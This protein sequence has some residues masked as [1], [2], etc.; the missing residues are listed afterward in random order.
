VI[1]YEAPQGRRVN[2]IGAYFTH[3][4]AV[5]TLCWASYASLPKSRAKTQQRSVAEQAVRHGLLPEEVGVLDSERFLAFLW[6]VAGRPFI[7]PAG[8][9]RER[10]LV[11]VLDNYSVHKSERVE[12]ALPELTAADIHLFYLPAYTPELSQMEPVWHAVKHHELT[13]R[14]F[15]IL[16]QLK[17]AVDAALARKATALYAAAQTAY[18][19]P[20]AA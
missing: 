18:L 12:A 14:S 20:L 13:Q 17:R 11:I 10:P 16:G 5:G 9:R 4:P 1:P 2:V 6:K 8:W 3:G 15:E 7:Y 19:L